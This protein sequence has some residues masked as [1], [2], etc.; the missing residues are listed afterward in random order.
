M[1]D[2]GKIVVAIYCVSEANP[3]AV[4]SWS[5]G[6]EALASG[7]EHAVSTDTTLLLLRDYNVSNF[8][9][10]SYTCVARNPLG[11]TRQEIQL[12]GTFEGFGFVQN[13]GKIS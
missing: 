8:L 4:V 13:D 6:S 2:D 3:P 5:R 10:H 11:S 7:V 9:L 12:R 1:D